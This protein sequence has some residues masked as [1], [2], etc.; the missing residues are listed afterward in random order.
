MRIW[1]LFMRQGTN[2]MNTLKVTI[3]QLEGTQDSTANQ[4]FITKIRKNNVELNHTLVHFFVAPQVLCYSTVNSSH[5]GISVTAGFLSITVLKN[6]LSW[7]Q[8]FKKKLYKCPLWLFGLRPFLDMPLEILFRSFT[9]MK[10][11]QT[12]EDDSTFEARSLIH[13]AE[14]CCMFQ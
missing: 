8:Y 6:N 13:N 11:Y 4:R 5:T 1:K 9:Q 10:H 2:Y 14:D 12:S 7:S 3:T